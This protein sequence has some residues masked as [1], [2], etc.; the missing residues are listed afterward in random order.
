MAN[1]SNLNVLN[2][3]FMNNSCN[4]GNGGAFNLLQYDLVEIKNSYF[5][6]N[7]PSILGLG[8]AIYIKT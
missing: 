2:S 4:N 3:S 1:I 5:S 7:K 8:G 6:S